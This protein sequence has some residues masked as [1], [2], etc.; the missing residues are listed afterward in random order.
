MATGTFVWYLNA[1]AKAFNKEIDWNSDS[2]KVIH[3]S[4]S[5]TPNQDA[6]DYANDFIANEVSGTNLAAGGIALSNCTVT[7]TGGTNTIKFDADDYSV[8]NVTVATA[9]KNSHIVDT[10]PGSDAT[11]PAIGYIVWNST[12]SPNAGTLAITF[13]AAGV[14]TIVPN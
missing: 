10:T 11:N 12:L 8:A 7:V 13:D 14:S 9:I 5:E 3:T 4:A 1:F 2:I 6:H